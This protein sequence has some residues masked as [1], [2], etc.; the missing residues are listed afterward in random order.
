MAAVAKYTAPIVPDLQR[1][2]F[3][4]NSTHELTAVLMGALARSAHEGS[5]QRV[6]LSCTCDASAPV[7][8]VSRARAPRPV[9]RALLP[10]SVRPAI[11]RAPGSRAS[12]R[13]ARARADTPPP[14]AAFC[15]RALMVR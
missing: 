6:I 13:L 15:T 7:R 2:A 1:Q 9:P 3:H 8:A 14:L 5:Q 10:A 11:A 12:L 4:D